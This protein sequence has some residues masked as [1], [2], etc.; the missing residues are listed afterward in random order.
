MPEEGAQRNDANY[1]F[2]HRIGSCFLA[3]FPHF[4]EEGV[5]LNNPWVPQQSKIQ[6]PSASQLYLDSEIFKGYLQW[7]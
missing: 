7:G 2:E 3:F 6:V 4:S 5:E 1:K